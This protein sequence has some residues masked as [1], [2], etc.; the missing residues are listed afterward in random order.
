MILDSQVYNKKTKHDMKKIII[1]NLFLI[2]LVTRHVESSVYFV[3]F[4][5]GDDSRNGT[6]PATSWKHSPGDPSA[7][8]IPYLFSQYSGLRINP[9]DVIKFKGGVTYRGTISS[10]ET[11]CGTTI[12]PK[13]VS[14]IGQS[15]FGNGKAIADGSE[16]IIGWTKCLSASACGGNP[17]YSKIWVSKTSNKTSSSSK[18][19]VMFQGDLPLFVSES[20]NLPDPTV[21]DDTA[22]FFTIDQAN[23]TSN[24]DRN[25]NYTSIADY[26]LEAMGGSKLIG[27]YVILWE[28][29]N[30]VSEHKI[31]GY[32]QV[33]KRI[34]FEWI[35]ENRI[36]RDRDNRYAIYNNLYSG[37]DKQGE[38]YFDEIPNGD[39]G[40]N[41]FIWPI[42]DVDPNTVIISISIIPSF[43]YM[44]VGCPVIVS[45]FR[46]AMFYSAAIQL[47]YGREDIRN[48]DVINLL[49]RFRLVQVLL[50]RPTLLW[51]KT[52]R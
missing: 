39:G 2:T 5:N 7:K 20:P 46:I 27:S 28:G 44:N 48:N 50:F 13:P 31:L 47:K 36:Y 17:N 52:T 4:E 49:D 15:D 19:C 26:R 41:V 40:H 51:L 8:G 12:N 23:V 21:F 33:N 18:N 1:I 32:D 29:N 35:S 25:P 38:V 22:N 45:G 16:P 42:D 3:D 43:F 34:D 9:G 24:L 11:T 14:W 30:V 10:M 6:T 37:L